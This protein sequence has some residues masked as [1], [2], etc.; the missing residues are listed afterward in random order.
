MADHYPQIIDAGLARDWAWLAHGRTNS[1][2]H[3]DMTPDEERA[4][5]TD[6]VD[7]IEK[8]TGQRPR[9]WMGPG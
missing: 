4:L 3:G 7:T 2:L 8:A 5:L 6:I 9:G 1:I